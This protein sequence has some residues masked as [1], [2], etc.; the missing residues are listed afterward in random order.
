MSDTTILSTGGAALLSLSG[1]TVRYGQFTALRHASLHIKQGEVVSIIGP[2]GAGKSTTLAAIAG[3]VS[4]AEGTIRFK[5][6]DMRGTSP[7]SRAHAG[8]SLVPEG[9]HVFSSLSVKENLLIGT[10]MRRNSKQAAED[11]ERVLTYFPRLRERLTFPAGKLSGG[12]QQML[13]IARAVMTRPRLLM[14]DEPSLGLAP[15]IIDQ[16]YEILRELREKEELT[17]LINE[18]SSNRLLKHS[19]RIYVLRGGQVQLEGL[20]TDL[21]DGEAIKRAYFGFEASVAP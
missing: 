14:I 10:Y 18:Q 16:I 9:R 5:N 11:Y 2:N 8:I 20:A 12:E 1:I 19:D 3:G 4:L 15:K 6:S 7:E 17:L 13:A 21:A